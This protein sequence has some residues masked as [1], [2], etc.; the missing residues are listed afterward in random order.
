MTTHARARARSLAWSRSSAKRRARRNVLEVRAARRRFPLL[1]IVR[2]AQPVLA[3]RWGSREA[4]TGRGRGTGGWL[5]FSWPPL[6]PAHAIVRDPRLLAD[7]LSPRQKNCEVQAAPSGKQPA[8][9]SFVGE[10]RE[11]VVP[12]LARDVTVALRG[13]A[14]RSSQ[15]CC[16][17]AARWPRATARESKTRWRHVAESPSP[18]HGSSARAKCGR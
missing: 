13:R 14:S 15:A 17:E 10:E 5:F 7:P 4:A 16:G 6:L 8:L 18:K 3:R 9:G 2:W 1:A 11:E 12:R